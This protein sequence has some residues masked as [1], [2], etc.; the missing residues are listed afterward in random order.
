MKY[1]P[2]VV[3]AFGVHHFVIYRHILK[4]ADAKQ[5]TKYYITIILLS[6]SSKSNIPY[7]LKRDLIRNAKYIPI[8]GHKCKRYTIR[9]YNIFTW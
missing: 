6:V 9:Y 4:L 2:R 3:A 5:Q 8:N 1:S 7:Q